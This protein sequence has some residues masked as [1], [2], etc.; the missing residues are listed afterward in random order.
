MYVSI[1]IMFQKGGSQFNM[2]SIILAGSGTIA[3]SF[4][5]E[6]GRRENEK[7]SGMP[8]RMHSSNNDGNTTL[9][10]LAKLQFKVS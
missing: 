9:T 8:L 1:K 5:R 7:E 6:G 4:R 10:S 3:L 2:I